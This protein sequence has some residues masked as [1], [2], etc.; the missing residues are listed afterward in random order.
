MAIR[1]VRLDDESERA[2]Q[3]VRRVTGLRVS[4]VLKRGLETLRAQLTHNAG[5]VAHDL[6]EE[7]DLGPG[8]Y[9]IAPSSRIKPA[10]RRAIRSKHR[11]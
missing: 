8:G 6:Y 11:R 9:A 7:L 2:L 10:V 5:G 1:T 4:D 3:E